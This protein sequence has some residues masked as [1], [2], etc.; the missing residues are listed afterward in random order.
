VS[1][2][3]FSDLRRRIKEAKTFRE[4]DRFLLVESEKVGG[5]DLLDPLAILDFASKAQSVSE[6][7]SKSDILM[8]ALQRA[9][10]IDGN[11]MTRLLG[12]PCWRQSDAQ[13]LFVSVVH[14][15]ALRLAQ[16]D[17]ESPLITANVFQNILVSLKSVIAVQQTL[18]D[19]KNNRTSKM[20][21]AAQDLLVEYVKNVRHDVPDLI[22][23]SARSLNDLLE[24]Q[25]F[26]NLKSPLQITNV[27]EVLRN[28]AQEVPRTPD[29]FLK[30]QRIREYCAIAIKQGLKPELIELTLSTLPSAK[31]L[32]LLPPV[33]MALVDAPDF[34]TLTAMLKKLPAEVTFDP[35]LLSLVT[36]LSHYVQASD[37][38]DICIA[39]FYRVSETIL[40]KDYQ[41]M[42]PEVF[43]LIPPALERMLVI[44]FRSSNTNLAL[45][46]IR[47]AQHFAMSLNPRSINNL[48]FLFLDH[49]LI[50]HVVAILEVACGIAPERRPGNIQDDIHEDAAASVSLFKVDAKLSP[51]NMKVFT[52]IIISVA[53]F[54]AWEF[55][56]RFVAI[57]RRL[58]ITLSDAFCKTALADA[59]VSGAKS[60]DR[61]L[62]AQLF[63][64]F[65]DVFVILSVRS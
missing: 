60:A 5:W 54:G 43:T 3:A 59:R 18:G 39:V 51:I 27:M 10:I 48:L 52:H 41:R 34:S 57:L 38:A 9:P 25:D 33:S 29:H 6:L 20:A 1:R 26:L 16:G 35:C 47:A 56:P 44:A 11:A 13:H 53:R 37:L 63:V 12:N 55:A 42:S 40:A 21:I 49:G 22:V 17:P 28:T 31:Y 7:V 65:D 32:G 46:V 64:D 23:Q 58:G 45:S 30:D 19:P 8:S 15:L 24:V 61:L 50:A 2:P 62:L 36:Q 4:A 14:S